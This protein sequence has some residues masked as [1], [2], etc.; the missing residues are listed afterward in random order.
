[1]KRE[2]KDVPDGHT[3]MHFVE[4]AS[5]EVYPAPQAT[6]ELALDAPEILEKYP[7]KHNVHDEDPDT[8]VYEPAEH[9]WHPDVVLT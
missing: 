1:M 7:G 6:H 2:V 8:F 4:P 3:K 9:C 5:F